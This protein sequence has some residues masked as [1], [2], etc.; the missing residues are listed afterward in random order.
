MAAAKIVSIGRGTLTIKKAL[1]KT[2]TGA[3]VGSSDAT[4]TKMPE[5]KLDAEVR[6]AA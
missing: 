2:T 5:R 4:V 6:P 1:R 3:R